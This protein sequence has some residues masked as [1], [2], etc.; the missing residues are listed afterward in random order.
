[1]S[2]FAV[3]LAGRVPAGLVMSEERSRIAGG[4]G[5]EVEAEAADCE[6]EFEVEEERFGV[7]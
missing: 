3:H 6:F 7:L 4:P 5:C 2:H 1:M